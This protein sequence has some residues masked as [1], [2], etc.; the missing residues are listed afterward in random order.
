MH[1]FHF[2]VLLLATVSFRLFRF[3]TGLIRPSSVTRHKF[4]KNPFSVSAILL[5]VL[6]PSLL[7]VILESTGMG[8]VSLFE[9]EKI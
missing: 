3:I 2:E 5:P 6:P 4:E 7:P 9:F 1:T 8:V